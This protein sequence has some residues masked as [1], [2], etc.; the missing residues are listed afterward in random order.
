M[1]QL[2]GQHNRLQSLG[3][4]LNQEPSARSWIT[5]GPAWAATA[6]SSY[7][8]QK[9]GS[10]EPD[11]PPGLGNRVPQGRRENRITEPT[12]LEKT[13][14]IA[15]S[16][17]R[18]NTT[19]STSLA[20]S[21]TPRAAPS[22]IT[23]GLPLAPHR[24]R[25]S[26]PRGCPS[27]RRRFP[28][29]GCLPSHRRHGPCPPQPRTHRGGGIAPSPTPRPLWR[30]RCRHVTA[31]SSS[32]SSPFSSSSSSSSAAAAMT[33]GAATVREHGER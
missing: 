22:F 19:V 24:P 20:P 10:P 23:P 9:G 27:H 11:P 25:P 18:P 21:L 14:E 3:L 12:R 13:S 4:P 26:S 31:A 33:G 28:R 16:D 6:I 29:R 30:R 32:C 5:R 1:K 2:S 8:C 15:E 7:E 17:L